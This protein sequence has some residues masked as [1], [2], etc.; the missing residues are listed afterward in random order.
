VPPLQL[1]LL[2]LLLRGMWL[3]TTLLTIAAVPSVG[4]LLTA[5]C[6]WDAAQAL[7]SQGA[8]LSVARSFDSRLAFTA[9]GVDD[10]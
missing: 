3:L 7:F 5:A 10:A 6:S 4:Y 9:G 2:L 8:R 1:L